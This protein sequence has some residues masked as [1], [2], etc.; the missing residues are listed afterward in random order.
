MKSCKFRQVVGVLRRDVETPRRSGGPRHDVAFHVAAWPSG[1]FGHPQVRHWV[2]E[3]HRYE[4]LR[5][6]IAVLRHDVATV[7]NMENC[8]VLV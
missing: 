2:E 4:G 5:R 1:E 6:S 8:C 7:H 3:P